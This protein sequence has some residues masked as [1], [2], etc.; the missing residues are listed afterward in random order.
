MQETSPEKDLPN[1]VWEKK[2]ENIYCIVTYIALV[3]EMGQID[4]GQWP[5]N[6][7]HFVRCCKQS[8]ANL[9]FV[10]K[11]SSCNNVPFFALRMKLF[12]I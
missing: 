7:C 11:N 1:R 8:Q 6:I 10:G 3:F 12:C 4:G 2:R 9:L 5:R